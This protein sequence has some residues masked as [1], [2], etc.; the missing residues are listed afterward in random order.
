MQVL[1]NPDGT[2]NRE[3]RPYIEQE[4]QGNSVYLYDPNVPFHYGLYDT[5]Q[6]SC[7]SWLDIYKQ[8]PSKTPLSVVNYTG[9]Q[10]LVRPWYWKHGHLY[11]PLL[12]ETYP[13]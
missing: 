13:S 11:R 7:G 8:Y 6:P 12:E 2:R 10:H 4:E 1:L 5:A 9:R 3:F